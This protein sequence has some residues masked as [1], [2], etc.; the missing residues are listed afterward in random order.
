M[1]HNNFIQAEIALKKSLETAINFNFFRNI[2]ASLNNLG[3]LYFKKGNWNQA[4]ENYEQAITKSQENNFTEGLLRSFNNL[5][6][7]YEKQGELNLAYDLYFKGL[8]MLPTVSDEFIKAEL[9]G[10]IG[11]ALTKLHRFKEAYSYLVESFDFFK[12]L[13]AKDKIIEGCQQQAYYFIMTRNYE[14]ADYYITQLMKLA[15]EINH[16]FELGRAFYLRALLER[17]NLEQAKEQLNE[18]IRLFVE[19]NNN[20]ELSLANYELASILNEQKEWEQ[21]LQILKNNKKII[22][23]FGSIK[24]LEQ[25]DILI[26]KISRDYSSQVSDAKFEETLLNQFY[27]ITQKLNTITDLDVLIEQALSS[28]I[29]ISEADGGILCL[30]NNP[31]V[32]ESWDYKVFHEYSQNDEYYDTFM[33]LMPASLD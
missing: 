26:Q 18:A 11:S 30:H 17:R 3:A 9:Y 32:P 28:L 7:L 31:S 1:D 6:E 19:T 16:P 24:L 20:Y 8:E 29:D 25:N 13:N 15:S 10:N 21:A 2:V 27:E 14:S 12:A 22:Q 23:Q 4:I 5:G 33:D